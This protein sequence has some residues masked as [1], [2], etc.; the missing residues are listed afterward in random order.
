MWILCR[1]ELMSLAM[2][3]RVE[4]AE[5]VSVDNSPSHKESLARSCDT[6]RGGLRGSGIGSTWPG[7]ARPLSEVAGEKAPG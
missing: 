7:N 4:A 5:A 2:L 3:R 6:A 1:K